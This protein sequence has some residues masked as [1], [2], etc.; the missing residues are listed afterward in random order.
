MYNNEHLGY[1]YVL[2]AWA[3]VQVQH[4]HISQRLNDHV[5]ALQ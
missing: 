4:I 5:E 2:L 1:S 3:K